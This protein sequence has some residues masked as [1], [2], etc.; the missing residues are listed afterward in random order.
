MI[1]ERRRQRVEENVDSWLMSYADMITLLLAFF[2]IFVSVS[3]PKQDRL[4]AIAAGMHEKFGAISLSTPFQGVFS[5]LQTVIEVHQVLKDVAV[6]RSE[7]SVTMELSALTFYQK[8]SAELNPDMLPV[9]TE[10]SDALRKI[11]YM[12]Y[13]IV[14]E[15]YT[16]DVPPP[17]GSGYASN[18]DLSSAR[19]ARMVRFLISRGLKPDRLRAVGYADTHPKVPNLDADGNAVP[20]NRKLNQRIIIRLER[21]LD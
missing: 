16:S 2:V 21:I 11:D 19:A 4:S 8:D 7:S 6:E 3:V 17:A 14:V 12:D 5:S 15:G 1:P 18:W 10:L 13:R 9:L 20:E